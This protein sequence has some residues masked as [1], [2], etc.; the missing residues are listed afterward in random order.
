MKIKLTILL[1]TLSLNNFASPM[2]YPKAPDPR[3]TPGSF[4][5][6]P[7]R[8]RHPEQI[9]YCERNVNTFLKETIFI[10]Y[11]KEL[12]YSLSGDRGNYK[13]D[14]YIP[15]CMGGSNKPDNLWPQHMTISVITDPIESA[16]CEMLGKGRITQKDLIELVI[17]AKNNLKEAPRIFNYLK[18]L[19]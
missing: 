9:P 2:S 4:C 19:R 14:H 13:V 17:K 5:D 18:S 11:R 16:G 8:Y 15:L 1:A 6:T 3:L 12:G 10:A 7:D